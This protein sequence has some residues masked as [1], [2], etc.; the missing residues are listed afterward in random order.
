MIYKFRCKLEVNQKVVTYDPQKREYLIGSIT[1]DY[2]HDTNKIS[3]EISDYAHLRKVDW[4]GSVS[5]DLL[6]VSSRNSLGSI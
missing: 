4:K 5:R 3:D 6:S 1:T 2:S